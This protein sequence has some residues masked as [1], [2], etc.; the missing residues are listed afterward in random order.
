MQREKRKG[1]PRFLV[2]LF[3]LFLF[4]SEEALAAPWPCRT[5]GPL[6][7]NGEKWITGGPNYHIVMNI[8]KEDG[9]IVKENAA[10]FDMANAKYS[11]ARSQWEFSLS[12]TVPDGSEIKA[13][14]IYYR[15]FYVD[16]EKGN[17][18]IVTLGNT[19]FEIN[20]TVSSDGDG[21]GVDDSEDNCPETENQDQVDTDLDGIGDVCDPDADGDGYNADTDCLDTDPAVHP[22]AEEI[23]DNGKD[24]DCNPETPDSS[25]DIDNDGDGVTENGGDCDDAKAAVHP[26][27]VE[28]CNGIDDNCNG[29]VDEGCQ[30]YYQDADADGFGNA[31][32]TMKATAQPAG[33]V[34]DNTDCLDSDAAVHPG[35]QEIVDN[36]KDDDCNPATLDNSLDIDND[37]DGVTENG[38]DCDDAKAAVHPGAVETCNGIDDNC[39]GQV[40]EG[41]RTYYQD[42]DADGFGNAA[43]TMKATAKPAGYVSDNTDCL[44]TD[45]AVHPGAQ[46]IVDNGK[47]DDC[48][49]ATLDNSLDIDN[50]GDGVTENGGD[51]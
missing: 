29:Q 22:G 34:L 20:A 41:C 16:G 26:G 1:L 43:V 18:S 7:I 39:N 40:D 45:A 6:I 31:A 10:S 8:E 51:C 14:D 24:D 3:F 15:V 33:Y 9:T 50:D 44:D 49:P 11:S 27:A 21:D 28:T 4:V 23:V 32:V 48:N 30:T 36:G 47:D 12:Y 35:A 25:L 37:G 5:I 42:T 38:G 13:N 19:L 46:E 17:R 2:F